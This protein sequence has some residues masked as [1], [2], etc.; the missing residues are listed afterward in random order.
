MTNHE[1]QKQVQALVKDLQRR[2]DGPTRF[3]SP[4][5]E[6]LQVIAI[7]MGTAILLL[8]EIA[9]RLPERGE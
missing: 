2:A 9:L 8:K 3:L 1:I 4:S 6:A 7:Q 5:E